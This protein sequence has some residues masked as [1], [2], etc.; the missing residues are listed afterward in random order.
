MRRV[1]KDPYLESPYNLMNSPYIST[2]T[3]K[4]IIGTISP[5]K[6]TAVLKYCILLN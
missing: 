3:T 4:K 1:L 6:K 2:F 5:F